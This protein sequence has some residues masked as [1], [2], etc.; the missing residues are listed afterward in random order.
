MGVLCVVNLFK[1]A[2]NT[3]SNSDK[4]SFESIDYKFSRVYLLKF[5][6]G[7]LGPCD[8]DLNNNYIGRRVSTSVKR[9]KV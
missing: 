1:E 4:G 3:V 8:I 9:N 7:Q 6:K 2:R 5:S